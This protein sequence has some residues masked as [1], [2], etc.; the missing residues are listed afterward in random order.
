MVL[1]DA[2]VPSVRENAQLCFRQPTREL[3]EM[4]DGT[5]TSSSPLTTWTGC[6]IVRAWWHHPVPWFG[7]PQSELERFVR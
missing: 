4:N 2:A 1:E 7:P 5:I 3:N 6:W